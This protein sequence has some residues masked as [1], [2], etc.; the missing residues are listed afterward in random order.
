MNSVFNANIGTPHDFFS[1]DISEHETQQIL[2][3]LFEQY[4]IFDCVTIAVGR[5]NKQLE[6]LIRNLG[7]S[8]VDQLISDGHLKFFL[9]TPVL[10]STTGRRSDNGKIDK[11]AIYGQLPIIAGTWGKEDLDPERN[12]KL[13]LD[14][15]DIYDLRKQQFLR[16]ASAAYI[17]PDGM[18][19]SQNATE[20]VYSSYSQNNLSDLGM[21]NVKEPTQLNL[22]ERKKFMNLSH[23]VLET[24][25]LSE[26][27]LKSYENYEA[28]QICKSNLANIGKA[29]NIAEN[30]SKIFEL[31]NLPDLKKIY[32]TG[33]MDFL[34]AFRIREY[35]TSKYYRDWIN[36]VGETSNSAEVAVEYIREIEGKNK[37]FESKTGKFLKNM[38]VFGIGSVLGEKLAQQ[39]LIGGTISTAGNYALGLFDEF[40][41]NNLLK[42]KNPSMFIRD[43]DYEI[44]TPAT[45]YKES[46]FQNR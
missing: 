30:T 10:V 4:L 8:A 40:I 45:L 39:P 35:G 41:L 33:K 12:I 37:F 34:A 7:L 43:I 44:A 20:L 31:N 16:K 15:F 14:K 23:K 1:Q 38:A 21:P 25:I 28:F 5:D 42:G 22:S 24:A 18:E 26:Y 32:L 19:L 17:V 29:Y 27:K 3:Q 46:D 13:A 6:F 9:W 36:K 11:S 2:S